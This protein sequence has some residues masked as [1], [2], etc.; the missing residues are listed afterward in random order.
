MPAKAAKVVLE[1]LK[2]V[3][4]K[5][6]GY[7][8]Y[9]ALVSVNVCLCVFLLNTFEENNALLAPCL[10]F[11]VHEGCKARF[12]EWKTVKAYK[13]QFVVAS[14]SSGSQWIQCTHG[15]RPVYVQLLTDSC[16]LMSCVTSWWTLFR[17]VCPRVWKAVDKNTAPASWLMVSTQWDGGSWRSVRDTEQHSCRTRF[18]EIRGLFRGY[19][20][21]FDS[22]VKKSG[23]VL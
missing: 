9:P 18:G 15:H 22:L 13:Q 19:E 10:R 11:S 6:S 4:A 14:S 12:D 2:L 8:S 16:T 20:S 7:P 1:P 5:C 21:Q 23:S 17:L 3:W